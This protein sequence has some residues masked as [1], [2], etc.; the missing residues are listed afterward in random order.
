MTAARQTTT[1]RE[2]QRSMVALVER[3]REIDIG[4][5]E[6]APTDV[7]SN[8]LRPRTKD[9]LE[10]ANE[11]VRCV[12]EAC[13]VSNVVEAMS[14]ASFELAMD[15]AVEETTRTA[16]SRVADIAFIAQ[17]ELR[18]RAA[19]LSALNLH[20]AT[21]LVAECDGAL[22]RLTKA[23][24][25]I[26]RAIARASGSTPHL[27]YVSE[28]ELSLRVRSCYARFRSRVLAGREE[29]ETPD[30]I[31]QRL[32]RAGAEIAVMVGLPI[33]PALRLGD[34]A[35]LRSLQQRIVSWLRSKERDPAGGQNVW[36]DVCAFVAMLSDV[37]RRQELFE[38]DARVVLGALEALAT[39]ADRVPESTLCELRAL[40]GRDDEVDELLAS[41]S[42]DLSRW[43]DVLERMAAEI[44]NR[45]PS[46]R[47]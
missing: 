23:L 31:E 4:T 16:I 41:G 22:R 33:Y 43:L 15:V 12:L 45:A 2:Y 19:R 1:Y 3:A 34:R 30:A 44:G 10:Q 18:Q 20:E 38:H 35:Q 37:N 24:S 7:L 8:E 46:R 21:V 32:R 40:E 28:L 26:D 5:F 39:A 14:G 17:V 36:R 13:E 25:A 9:L 27:E 47:P 29:L 11:L 42:C 6:S